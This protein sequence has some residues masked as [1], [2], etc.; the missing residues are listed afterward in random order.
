MIILRIKN[1]LCFSSDL[2]METLAKRAADRG[3]GMMEFDQALLQFLFHLESCDEA[4]EIFDE[5]SICPVCSAIAKDGVME[6]KDPLDLI[7]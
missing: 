2:V 4:V 6:H 1:E 3:V 5:F 7:Q